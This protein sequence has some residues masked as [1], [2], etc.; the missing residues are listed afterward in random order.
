MNLDE[1]INEIA[2]KIGHRVSADAQSLGLI[3]LEG[4]RSL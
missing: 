3:K 1:T 2:W 4:I